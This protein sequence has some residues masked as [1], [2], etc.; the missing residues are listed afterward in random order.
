MVGCLCR[1][2][3]SGYRR[4]TTT[5]TRSWPV[6]RGRTPFVLGKTSAIVR[7]TLPRGQARCIPCGLLVVAVV[8]LLSRLSTKYRMGTMLFKLYL[9]KYPSGH[10]RCGCTPSFVSHIPRRRRAPPSQSAH[11]SALPDRSRNSAVTRDGWFQ[12]C[13]CG[14]I[15]TRYSGTDK[16]ELTTTGAE[17]V[18]YIADI[19]SKGE[20]KC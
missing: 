14:W 3:G 6:Q 5:T 12:R 18:V 2:C 17:A 11:G 8:R 15:P 9:T 1:E 16:N 7:T 10:H 13:I 19:Y 4:Q 20:Y